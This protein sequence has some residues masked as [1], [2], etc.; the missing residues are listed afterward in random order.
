L[1]LAVSRSVNSAVGCFLFNMKMESNQPF[2]EASF[3]QLD[4]VN[5][6]GEP[7]EELVSLAGLLPAGAK[8][9]D[10][11]CGEGRNA[12]YLAEQGLHVTAI[13][14]SAAGIAKLKHFADQKGLCVTAEVRDMKR[15]VFT[16]KYDLIVAHGSLHLIER[17]HW[18]SLF[19][20]MKANTKMGGYNVVVIFTDSLPP[21][22]DLKDF[23]V[24]LFREGEL[25]D[26]Y[27]DWR[28][29]E[30]QSYVLHDEHPGNIK[31][32]HPINKLVAQKQ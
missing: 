27:K 26:F 2:W 5:T 19:R 18:T 29:V 28:I 16:D 20:E 15:Y 22:D 23:H 11:G 31:H 4:A 25:F 14:V 9:L 17:E 24:G 6:F 10:I 1:L 30:K 7:A 3:S 13:D 12:L 32:Q 21:P 8:V